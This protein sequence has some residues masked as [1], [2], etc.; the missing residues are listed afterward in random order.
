VLRAPRHLRQRPEA[1]LFLAP[2][3]ALYGLFVL[4]PLLQVVWL[5]LQR[6]NGYGPQTW[7]GAGNYA[8]LFG[9]GVFRAA[10]LH[11]VAWEVAGGLLPALL[12]LGLAL[13]VRQARARTALLTAL[14]VP[15]LL[16]ATVVAALWTLVYSPLSGL[17]N[18]LLRDLGLG[19][20][21]AD[22][23]GDPRLALGA[24]FAAWLWSTIGVGTLI[25]WSGLQ[26][27]DGEY[28]LLAR[29]EGAGPLW[30]FAHVTL[31]GLRRTG[32]LVLLVDAALAAQVF[33]LVFVT[34]GGGPGYATM[35]LPLDMYGRAFGGHT[36]QGAATACVQIALGLVLAGLAL[37]LARTEGTLQ[38][39]EAEAP[40]SRGPG[41]VAATAALAAAVAV[42]LLPFAWLLLA[43]IEPGRAFALTGGRQIAD[44]RTLTGAQF[45]AAWNA[46]MG[47]ALGESLSLAA[48]AVAGTLALSVPAAFALS[49]VLRGRR[50][51]AVILGVLL[52]GLFL[53][54]P[55]LIIPLFTL[56]RDLG[57]LDTVW[58]V[59]LPEIARALPFAVL[60]LWASLSGGPVE[61]FQAAEVDGASPLQRMLR[62]ALPLARPALYA[63]GVWAFVS[64]WNEYLLPTVVSQDGSLQT[65]P[66]LL[67]TFLGKSNTQY[68][69]LAAASALAIL[70]T[71]ALLLA[72]WLPA[73]RGMQRIGRAL[74]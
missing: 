46:G 70:P 63:A 41:R 40:A 12:G 33:D 34:T 2:A 1:A 26:A 32:A 51:R 53:P 74:R 52:L 47:G 23:L 50:R 69:P 25:L 13:L 16:P 30:R 43:A 59:L 37:A 64:S 7:I 24:L 14:F 29:A 44:L 31:P 57:L 60:L 68:G 5:S 66:T 6:W 48:A 54:T 45:A 17:L 39:G 56:L 10:L 27:I 8:T 49:Q 35:L 73:A 9:D 20:L 72:V 55:V 65:V 36:G 28:Y 15:V 61:V 4:W 71:L 11:S 67:A 19:A 18:T 42:L 62:I 22:W 21:A 58:G 38:L 3:L